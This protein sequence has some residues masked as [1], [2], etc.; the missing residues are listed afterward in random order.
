MKHKDARSRARS[1]A[2]GVAV[3]GKDAG[4]VAGVGHLGV[5]IVAE[6]LPLF[7]HIEGV[8]DFTTPGREP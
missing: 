2:G 5:P 4:E 8:L 6:A 1:R 3:I 7:T